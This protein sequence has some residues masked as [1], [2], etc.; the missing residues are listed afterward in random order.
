MPTIKQNLTFTL[1]T[2]KKKDRIREYAAREI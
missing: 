2:K 1:Q